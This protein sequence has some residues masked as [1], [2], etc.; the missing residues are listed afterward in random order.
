MW[1]SRAEPYAR[2]VGRVTTACILALLVGFGSGFAAGHGSAPSA[3]A[4]TSMCGTRCAAAYTAIARALPAD[5][6]AGLAH[7]VLTTPGFDY[8]RLARALGVPTNAQLR[9]QWRRR[10]DARFP[11]DSA[12][13]NACF[14]LI[15]PSTYRYLD[16][17]SA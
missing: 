14:R 17:L 5:R 4:R 15:L 9:A 1:R 3:A 11:E 8:G 12:S 2:R 13:A 10:C 7:A 16:E 6:A